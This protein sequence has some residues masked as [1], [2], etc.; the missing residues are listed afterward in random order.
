VP[1]LLSQ[2]GYF[3]PNDRSKAEH[4]EERDQRQ[5][6]R[7]NPTEAQPAKPAD[8]WCQQKAQQDC[9]CDRDNDVASE[10]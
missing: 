4:G 5:R 1:S 9:K 8:R 3:L 10:I 6:N 7:G 2:R